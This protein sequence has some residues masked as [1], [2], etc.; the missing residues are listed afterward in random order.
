MF[1]GRHSESVG[2]RLS[3]N[4]R[5]LLNNAAKNRKRFNQ[6]EKNFSFHRNVLGRQSVVNCTNVIAQ[7]NYRRKLILF[8]VKCCVNWI[9]TIWVKTPSGEE[10]YTC[11]WISSSSLKLQA[12][13][14]HRFPSVNL[15]MYEY[16]W[17]LLLWNFK[18]Q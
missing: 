18:L 15:W 8:I 5:Q 7:F 4:H 12:L 2:L 17:M 6:R 13:P 10:D 11:L 9:K 14:F 1:Y 3:N 16:E